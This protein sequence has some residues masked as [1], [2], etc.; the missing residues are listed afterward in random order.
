M[1]SFETPTCFISGFIG[2]T[3]NHNEIL[4]IIV[5]ICLPYIPSNEWPKR[6][7]IELI[8]FEYKINSYCPIEHTAT[9][10]KT[11]KYGEFTI[12]GFIR[13]MEQLV[14]P[15]R[16]PSDVT[17]LCWK[18]YGD[19]TYVLSARNLIEI[20]KDITADAVNIKNKISYFIQLWTPHKQRSYIKASTQNILKSLRLLL[21]HKD[22]KVRSN[23][24]RAIRYLCCDKTLI[25]NMNKLNIPI[26]IMRCAMREEQ[27]YSFETLQ[28]FKWCSNLIKYYP[29]CVAKCCVMTFISI[30]T[31]AKVEYEFRKMC[32]HFLISIALGNPEVMYRCN[33]FKVLFNSIMIP[34]LKDISNALIRCILILLDNPSCRKYIPMT[35]VE[36]L[37]SPFID[38]P[39]STRLLND[40]KDK[41]REI[42][43]NI[44]IAM[45]N[46]PTGL[47]YLTGDHS[48][49]KKRPILRI[50]IDIMKLPNNVS[51]MQWSRNC[52]FNILETLLLPLSQLND[53]N[54]TNLILNKI[55]LIVISFIKNGL[56]ECLADVVKRSDLDM[57]VR[58]RILLQ[59]IQFLSTI[60]LPIK[61]YLT[62]KQKQILLSISKKIELNLENII[63][64]TVAEIID[65]NSMEKQ[66]K[67]EEKKQYK[68][69]FLE[70]IC[71]RLGTVCDLNSCFIRYHD[72]VSDNRKSQSTQPTLQN[73]VITQKSRKEILNLIKKS[74][75]IYTNDFMLRD[76]NIV[77]KI[78]NEAILW[79]EAHFKHVLKETKFFK[80]LVG[81]LKPSR[82]SFSCIHWNVVNIIH[83][84]CAIQLFRVLL[85]YNEEGEFKRF[86]ELIKEIF[87]YLKKQIEHNLTSYNSIGNVNVTKRKA[88]SDCLFTPYLMNNTLTRT[89]MILIGILTET[90][91][92]L[93]YFQKHNMFAFLFSIIT[94]E[95]NQYGV[96]RKHSPNGYL[97]REIAINLDYTYCQT[98]RLLFCQWL[99]KGSYCLRKALLNHLETLIVYRKK[100]PD[101]NE[102]IIQML[103]SLLKCENK[104]K[105]Q[106]TASV[107]HATQLLEKMICLLDNHT[108]SQQFLN[109]LI[110]T[111]PSD[112]IIGNY[113]QF[114]FVKMLST[115]KG[116]QYLQSI[117][118]LENK[119]VS[120]KSQMHTKYTVI[121]ETALKITEA[122]FSGKMECINDEN[123]DEYKS[124]DK[125]DQKSDFKQSENVLSLYEHLIYENKAMK[126][127]A[128][129]EYLMRFPWILT[130]EIMYG[131]GS[132]ETVQTDC[133][134]DF[135]FCYYKEDTVEPISLGPCINGLILSRSTV[136]KVT[137]GNTIKITINIGDRCLNKLYNNELLIKS[138]P[139]NNFKKC[140]L[141][142]MSYSMINE[143]K[144][145]CFFDENVLSRI[146]VSFKNCRK[147]KIHCIVKP[148]P[149]L[150]GEL[151][152]TNEGSKYM[153]SHNEFNNDLKEFIMTVHN[154]CIQTDDNYS[155]D[156]ILNLKS[157]LWALGTVGSSET[158]LK[159]LYTLSDNIIN[160][161]N[162]LC[163][164]S[165][166]L[167]IRVTCLHVLGLMNKQ[168]LNIDNVFKIE[169]TDYSNAY[170]Q[171]T[172]ISCY[173]PPQ[174][175]RPNNMKPSDL[176]ELLGEQGHGEEAVLAHISGLN[177]V[178]TQK[179]CASALHKMRAKKPS[180]FANTF[181]YREVLKLLNTY[182]YSLP[183][184]RFVLFALFDKVVFD[185]RH[186]K[187]ID[188]FDESLDEPI[189]E[190][191]S[192]REWRYRYKTL[193]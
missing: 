14:T 56:I 36:Q 119:R 127:N 169:C 40:K 43:E 105:H 22:V 163:Q 166:I 54:C 17:Y 61:N 55:V 116:F 140:R 146:V 28:A 81:Y 42:T 189:I 93:K 99:I 62:T 9:A 16:I 26:F 89:Y 155:M 142:N 184:K 18:Y 177:N 157:C 152:Q 27:K 192:I 158:G 109:A 53:H 173:A 187:S 35:Y 11:D 49:N 153:L 64:H 97:Y 161:I 136:Y 176:N 19:S 135:N 165:P 132:T 174:L 46:S 193:Q 126:E 178:V 31:N 168:E 41:V 147:N 110:E 148:L 171:N 88:K 75:V 141:N 150:Y 70:T 183:A 164:Q 7:V 57:T 188:L 32:I 115:C 191:K 144:I 154:A 172:N 122:N 167:S 74:N 50:L 123:E 58:S 129:V 25:N 91:T 186:I 60:S 79:S 59:Q 137:S 73:T 77:L 112:S 134:F 179:L 181:L 106:D 44:L 3:D 20:L 21:V 95:I 103:I 92:G 120:W 113:G 29:K 2:H 6:L 37:L 124:E 96:N 23:A 156:N 5:D 24:C 13:H 107:L 67:H 38:I 45:L 90:K 34:E 128:N 84:K 69:M 4:Q 143:G 8:K 151:A 125:M 87:D 98:A 71:E 175:C 190:W 94:K 82:Q 149:H 180:L 12:F 66:Q 121:L 139:V 85:R 83:A 102:W 133:F 104:M 130:A 76:M 80:I 86:D 63:Q 47:L 159:L 108:E 15:T 52:L 68:E 30:A 131:S 65:N 51:S 114:L 101:F 1:S 138:L 162:V 111:Q 145:F 33:G 160:D 10:H 185:S 78:L 170:L 117:N 182:E 100:I 39:V 48:N 118:W 72:I